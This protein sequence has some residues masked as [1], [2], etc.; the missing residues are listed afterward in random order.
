M[1][2]ISRCESEECYNV[3]AFDLDGREAVERPE[4][5]ELS[6]AP[7]HV[8][9]HDIPPILSLDFNQEG[10]KYHHGTRNR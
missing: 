6:A 3:R 4:S 1:G 10:H 7:E 8:S 9:A 5:E 2:F